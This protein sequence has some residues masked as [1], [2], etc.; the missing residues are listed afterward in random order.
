NASAPAPAPAPKE[1]GKEKEKEAGQDDEH[2]NL[3]RDVGPDYKKY[4]PRI[5]GDNISQQAFFEKGFLSFYRVCY[6]DTDVGFT[7]YQPQFI[8]AAI[9][10]MGR[11]ILEN[12]RN[13]PVELAF[14]DTRTS[15]VPEHKKAVSI[16][17]GQYHQVV[18][19]CFFAV[20]REFERLGVVSVMGENYAPLELT[21]E[22]LAALTRE[23][24]GAQP[25]R[26]R[27]EDDPVS[28]VSVGTE[29]SIGRGSGYGG[30]ENADYLDG[31]V[32]EGEGE[33]EGGASSSSSKRKRK[34]VDAEDYGEGPSGEV[35][36]E[37]LSR[38]A[39]V[40]K[41]TVNSSAMSLDS[42]N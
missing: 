24:N 23:T 1:K 13:V 20:C 37:P 36:E 6:Q 22:N 11:G 42:T 3:L 7:I 39:A 17:N 31:A 28:E 10:C 29:Y 5:E 35:A 30:S 4:L 38:G 33:G 15:L 26:P 2:A 32:S 34:S 27:G 18:K 9:T 12:M 19:R 16:L 40:M 21:A 25:D 41:N 8:K 14:A